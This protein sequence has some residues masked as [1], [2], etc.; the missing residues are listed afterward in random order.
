M[1]QQNI[2]DNDA[3]FEGYSRLRARRVNANNLFEI[4]AFMALVPELE[5]KAVLDLGCGMGER[6]MDYIRQGA[7]RVVGIDLSENMLAVA[8]E[9]HS[10]PRIEYLRLPM[11][12][13]GELEG[14][15]DLV[16]SSLALHYVQ[17]YAGVVSAVYGLLKPGG[18]FVFSQEHPL[19]TCFSTGERWTRDANGEKIFANIS[20]Y[21]VDGERET[22][23]FVPGLK[24]YHR[25]FSTVVN[26][27]I[28]AGFTLQRLVEPIPTP[29]LLEAYPDYADLLHKPDFLLVSAKKRRDKD[30]FVGLTF[31]E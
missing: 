13:I 6:C 28:D 19:T 23:W 21:S 22:T 17:D 3:F 8:R 5:G 10:H 24:I 31:R 18:E 1:A 4:P 7:A 14:R 30:G 20:D 12:R 11:E 29:E 2:Y 27:L 26:T 25:T 16:V 15:F 9:K